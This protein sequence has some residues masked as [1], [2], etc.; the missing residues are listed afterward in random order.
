MES[1]AL[2]PVKLIAPAFII[3]PVPGVVCP[4]IIFPP[5]EEIPE[6][7]NWFEKVVPVTVTPVP[8]V[9]SFSDPVPYSWTYWAAPV[10]PAIIAL[11]VSSSNLKALPLV[12]KSRVF[13]DLIVLPTPATPVSIW[14][15]A[16]SGVTPFL[17][18]T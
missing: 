6:T 11:V 17:K 16:G 13:E 3:D 4:T 9:L 12:T 2:G 8:M 10:P 7:L 15:V 1:E 14:R 18:N 5:I